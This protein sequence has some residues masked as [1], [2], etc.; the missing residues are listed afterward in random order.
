MKK[1]SAHI[2]RGAA[3]ANSGPGSFKALFGGDNKKYWRALK[4]RQAEMTP[5]DVLF[6]ECLRGRRRVSEIVAEGRRYP[7]L[8]EACRDLQPLASEKTIYRWIKGGM[9][10]EEAF[11]RVPNRGIAD[12][13]IYAVRHGASGKAYVGL[14][15]QTLERRWEFHCYQ[16]TRGSITGLDSLHAAI[17]EHG[18]DAFSMVEL[19]RGAAKK[20]LEDKER[21][22]IRKLG[23]LAPNGFNLHAGGVSGG[24]NKVPQVVDGKPFPGLTEAA[25]YVAKTRNISV[26]AAKKRIQVGRID[27]RTPAK[28]GQSLVKTKE[29]K[30]WS[31]IVHTVINPK[32]AKDHIPGVTLYEPWRDFHVFLA[33][34]GEAPGERYALFRV[35]RDRGYEPGNVRWMP[36]DEAYEV[37][38]Y[39]GQ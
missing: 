12:G 14:T 2:N 11:C 18:P 34:V 13:I 29:Y 20:D 21:R 25:A 4:R 1:I 26:A 8:K 31:H 23:T 30:A 39:G 36:R 32:A 27:V 7:N 19:D 5:A 16:A 6:P 35:D 38:G 33:D 24:R 17:R 28:P 10:P 37:A 9:S 3:L 22:W 15:V